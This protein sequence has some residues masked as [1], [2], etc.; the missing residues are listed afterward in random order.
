ME[1]RRDKRA[2]KAQATTKRELIVAHWTELGRPAVGAS[3]LIAIQHELVGRF[4]Q[5]ARDSPAFIA[6]VLAD[7]GA[8]LR[9]PEIIEC[10][11]LWRAQR[12]QAQAEQF[13]EI[14]SLTTGKALTLKQAEVLIEKLD[15]LRNRFD[16]SDAVDAS[17]TQRLRLFAVEARNAAQLEAKK[18]SLNEVQRAEQAEIAEW[19][20]VWIKTPKLFKDWLDLRRR[21]TD[22]R[23]RFPGESQ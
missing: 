14:V 12:I 20:G 21:A 23:Q 8:E 17:D 15:E 3:E 18:K 7:E 10:D 2:N 16:T 9:H 6:R 19:L 22:F 5:S 4:G 11:T 13:S 1:A